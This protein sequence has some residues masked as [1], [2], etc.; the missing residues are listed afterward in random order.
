MQSATKLLEAAVFCKRQGTFKRWHRRKSSER[1]KINISS[2]GVE[3]FDIIGCHWRE[4]GGGMRKTSS[5]AEPARFSVV[6]V[7][8]DER[9]RPEAE[10]YLSGE[11]DLLVLQT[12][13]ELIVLI[14][15]QPMDCVLLDL[16]TV[17]EHSKDGITA[18]GE[19]RALR[20]ELVLVGLTRSNSRNLRLQA[21]AAT[22]DEYFVAPINF[23]EVRRVLW[24]A[25]E[26]RVLEVECRQLQS[27]RAQQ[28][29]FCELIG[30]SEPMRR[31]YDAITRVAESTSTVLIRGESGTGKELVA[32]AIH[33]NSPRAARPFGA[34][35][36]AAI[37]ESL[38]ES[39][40]FG[41]EK[42]AFTGANA[43][44]KGRMEA[45]EGGTIFLDEVGELAPSLQAKLL[46]VLQEREFERVGGT[47]PIKLDVRVIAATNV[48]LSESVK[49]GSFRR[50][51]FYRLNVVALTMPALRERREDI[52]QLAGYFITKASRKCNTRSKPLSAEAG[53]LLASYDWPGNVRELENAIERAL[54]LGST[55]T[56]LPED[57]PE[58]LLE[59]GL[60][61]ATGAT[62]FHVAI[63][64]FKR[65]IILQ[66]LQQAHGG[67]IEAANALG[68]H[69]NSLLRLMRTLDLKGAVKGGVPPQEGE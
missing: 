27:Q 32:R 57:L 34:I 50:D 29:S 37:T 55:T 40:L 43:Q 22:V 11:Y 41:H 45:A 25:L 1:T 66:A 24:R 69:P 21:V 8:T 6:I 61:V 35:N 12:W 23:E 20:P 7:T 58:S 65:Q 16:D 5:R 59:A 9:V 4:K 33:R 56:I 17:G 44:K 64:N 68:L 31:V 51:L 10:T 30:G 67:Y 52:P 48:N 42:G 19:L 49:A 46:R 39:E 63:K 53:A 18:L 26:K 54:V 47:R 3:N 36:C 28:E 2:Q 60:P 14:N 62:N 38:L 13:D 15:K